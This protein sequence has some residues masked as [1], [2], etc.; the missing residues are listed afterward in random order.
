MLN[1]KKLTS[2]VLIAAL[3]ASSLV[4]APNVA[5][6]KTFNDVPKN[7]W[8]YNVIDEISNAK[9][10]N[11]TAQNVFSPKKVLTRAE[12]TAILYNMAPDKHS[13]P[14]FEMS[15]LS[16]N[17]W[18]YDVA[19]WGVSNGIIF[20]IKG[21]FAGNEK[22][23]RQ[24]MAFMTANF[25]DKYYP[26]ALDETLPYPTFTDSDQ[27]DENYKNSVYILAANKLIVGVGNNKF[28]PKA[29]LTRAEAAAMASRVMNLEKEEP[30]KPPVKPEEP[31][32]PPTD[33]QEP[34]EPEEPQKPVDPKPEEPEQ[35]PV[36]EAKPYP[37]DENAPEW[38][39]GIKQYADPEETKIKTVYI[40]KPS[41]M[42]SSQ[43]EDL[44]DYYKDKEKPTDY[45]SPQYPSSIVP[46][47]K[48]SAENL[49]IA[50][51]PNLY[52]K[53]QHE[54]AKTAIEEGDANLSA[55]EQKMV[56]LVNKARREAGVPELKVS[57]KLCE[58]AEI[59]AKECNI[60]YSHTRP[61]GTNCDTVLKDV[62]LDMKL[63]NG[64]Q[65]FDYAGNL[66]GS[67]KLNYS[68]DRAFQ[69]LLQS[70]KHRENILNA[71]YKYIGVAFEA[72][73][74]ESAWIQS[75]I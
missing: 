57:P 73:K 46:Y 15:D 56:D 1:S 16:S 60:K 53:M 31:E 69:A 27:I 68:A 42:T 10:M 3:S 44:K 13:S 62:G 20:P 51:V 32:Q 7:Y 26:N 49:A 37:G 38:L 34:S 72:S 43:W 59:R 12:Y 74:T 40:T 28:A 66:A 63:L 45:P 24:Y 70:K 48:I 19:K 22:V 11:G 64:N 17:D 23:D 65:V 50:F 36:D 39:I 71:S 29:T 41:N 8:A 2:A 21:Q 75:F 18:F 47:G 5:E 58:A 6:A 33:P 61:D 52:D 25:L 30:E 4:V 14:T 54:K 35:P 67:Y 9:V 55:E